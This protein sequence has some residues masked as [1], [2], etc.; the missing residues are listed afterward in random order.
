LDLFT[1]Q[2]ELHRINNIKIGFVGDNE[3]SRTVHSLAKLLQRFENNQIFMINDMKSFEKL[4]QEIDVL[5][6]TRH[7]KERSQYK[8]YEDLIVN[9]DVIKNAKDNMIIM[10]PLP[11]NDELSIDLD[12]NKR[13]VY[14]KQVQNGVYMRMA[15]LKKLCNNK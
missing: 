13:S 7:Q 8:N 14:F 5:Y 3:N 12:S 6:V 2:E 11:R 1:I 15:I 4:I 10:H 9:T